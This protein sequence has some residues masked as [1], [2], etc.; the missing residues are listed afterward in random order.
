MKASSI[1][2]LK[3]AI[4]GLVLVAALYFANYFVTPAIVGEKLET[5]FRPHLSSVFDSNAWKQADQRAPTNAISIPY[6]KRYEM[7][8]NLLASKLLLGADEL[9][10]RE[11]LGAPESTSEQS[12]TK[13][14][15]YFLA[16]QR[17]YPARSILFPGLFANLD[18]WMFEVLLR[19]GK[20]VLARVYFT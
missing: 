3:M 7:V 5:C 4:S 8:D 20:V 2:P 13:R 12:G 17:Q 10:L 6:G 14:F 16:D 15:Y 18:R 9:R 1:S 19:D 11:L